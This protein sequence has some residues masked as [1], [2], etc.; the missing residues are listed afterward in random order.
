MNLTQAIITMVTATN[1]HK[2]RLS[3]ALWRGFTEDLFGNEDLEIKT[4]GPLHRI[5][6]AEL[7][8]DPDIRGFIV[9]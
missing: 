2:V 1:A 7:V 4:S 5:C 8:I 9:E 3:P 6:G